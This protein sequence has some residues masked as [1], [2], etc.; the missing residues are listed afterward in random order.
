MNNNKDCILAYD[1]GTSSLKASVVE[2][3]GKVIASFAKTYPTYDY[4]DGRREQRPSDWWTC[5]LEIT[6]VLFTENEDLRNRIAAISVSGHSLG[7]VAVGKDGSLLDE[8]TPI[9]SDTRAARQA[10]KFFMKISGKEWYRK[11]GNGFHACLYSV[12]KIMWYKDNRPQIYKDAVKFLGSKDYLNYLL[13][14]VMAT[15]HSYAS[16]S[17]V[18]NLEKGCYDKAL[19]QASGIPEEKFAKIV[20]S[21]D[22]LG[23]LSEKTAAL[24]GLPENVRVVAGGVDNACMSLG[25]GCMNDGDAYV[26]LGSSAW[27][28][29]ACEKPKTD[30][31]ERV[32]IWAHCIRGRYLPSA[33]I[34]S[35]GSALDWAMKRFSGQENVA[36]LDQLV[37]DVE[38]G[39][40]GVLF[41]PV[42]S[43][44]ASTDV[45]PTMKGMLCGLSLGTTR[46][47]IMR[48]VLEGI[49]MEM[50]IAAEAIDSVSPIGDTVRFVGGAA[51]K[52]L[53]AIFADVWDKKIER[54]SVGR[55]CATLGAAALAFVGV[56]LWKNYDLLYLLNGSDERFEPN[57]ENVK[58]YGRILE[59]FRLACKCSAELC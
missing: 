42:L 16:G 18:Y 58:I 36:N 14:G 2:I 49:A 13:C 1:L 23:T 32:N 11:T 52:P 28:A 6:S 40:N 46:G 5:L 25:A 29:E 31:R 20:G 51:V 27:I 53:L 47:E 15:D 38:K 41:L 8:R 35:A 30:E 26:S 44:G 37:A 17:G 57:K 4:A 56:G 39:A 50:K 54:S 59:R 7:V 22:V 33:G 24:L 45:S 3:S 48:A 55:Q 9:W 43:G 12:F 19:L 21:S 10:E 34:Y